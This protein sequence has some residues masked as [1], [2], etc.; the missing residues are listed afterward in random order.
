M[1][2]TDQT[3]WLKK[4]TLLASIPDKELQKVR[5]SKRTLAAGEALFHMGDPASAAFVVVSGRLKILRIADADGRELLLDIVG[6][7]AVLGELAVFDDAPRSATIVA[8]A[9]SELVAIDRR[10][11]MAVV[12][13]HPDVAVKLLAALA[14]ERCAP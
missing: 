3:A 6:P 8:L 7:G 10:D 14:G 1:K 11:F 12:R 2:S 9:D 5:T 13:A 4:L